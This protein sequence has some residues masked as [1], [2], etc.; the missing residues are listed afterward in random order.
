MFACDWNQFYQS[1]TAPPTSERGNRS[2]PSSRKEGVNSRIM[3]HGPDNWDQFI[4]FAR[5]KADLNQ[6]SLV[7][8][9]EAGWQMNWEGRKMNNDHAV[10]AVTKE[11]I[12][13]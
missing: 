10:S 3:N 6:S 11:N 1:Q 7:R 9:R 12:G 2:R 13:S 4:T 5:E 8:V